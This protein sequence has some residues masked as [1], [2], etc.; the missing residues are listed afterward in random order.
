MILK[1]AY[2]VL[3]YLRT[4]W[5]TQKY[6][7]AYHAYNIHFWGIKKSFVLNPIRPA[8]FYGQWGDA[9]WKT[10]K[11]QMML[12]I[13]FNDL[14]VKSYSH[15]LNSSICDT[16]VCVP[17]AYPMGYAASEMRIIHLRKIYFRN[18][19]ITPLLYLSFT[20]LILQI[21]SDKAFNF[22]KSKCSLFSQKLSIW[23]NMFLH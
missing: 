18:M 9:D 6:K 12:L 1:R 22:F 10:E 2:C 20:C 15:F 16:S 14:S 8:E 11:N 4:R 21:V 17:I 19:D 5:G 23:E 3:A 13:S 7:S